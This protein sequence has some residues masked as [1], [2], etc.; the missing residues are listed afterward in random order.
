MFT[1]PV[2]FMKAF[3][4]AASGWDLANAHD[5]GY[6]FSVI[7][8]DTVNNGVVV[9]TDGTK[10][11]TIGNTT[12]SIYQYTLSTAGDIRTASYDSVSFSY[13]TQGT[14]GND[15]FF[16]PDGTA[17]YYVDSGTGF[18]YQYTLSTPWDLS[19]ASYASK[20]FSVVSQETNSLGLTFKSDGTKM[21]IVGNTNDTVYQ[22]TLSTA[23]D[24]STASYDSVSF[25][26]AA[27]DGNPSGIVFKSDGTKMYIVGSASDN[28]Y[29]YTLSTP[30]NVSTATYDS[31]LFYV[32]ILENTPTGLYASS[33]GTKMYLVGTGEDRVLQVNLSSGWD[34][35]TA[36]GDFDVANVTGQMSTVYSLHFKPDGTKM[37]AGTSEVPDAVYQYT[38]S[39][40]WDTD[41]ASYDSVFKDV[42]AQLTG[43]E[44]LTFSVD[45]TK[46]YVTCLAGTGDNT[47]FQYTLSTPWNLSTASYASKSFDFT[48]QDISPVEVWFKTDGTKMYMFGIAGNSVYQ[49]SLSTAWDVSTATYDS[50][51]FSVAAQETGGRGLCFSYDGDKM[52]ISGA[53]TDN[54][55]Q[56][57]LSTPWNLSTASYDSKFFYVGDWG[58]A[59]RQ[60]F[61]KQD[62]GMKMYIAVTS[63]VKQFSLAA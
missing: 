57:T 8:E 38:L 58:A 5:D 22:Y 40:P 63:F 56:Y 9:S 3:E 41:T 10:M 4:A 29:Q 25:S 35:S 47:I 17:F 50:V 59:A 19:T 15:L 27:Q 12:D 1:F 44:G 48:T 54:I 32:G 33:D 21:Y 30:W 20:S 55:Y 62:D 14:T 34:L 28:I 49:Y 52:F 11:Y 46:M 61:I 43:F 23:W 31:V 18:V 51:S 45:G 13:A 2:G 26:V 36:T 60:V 42:S 39:T 24:V 6:N 16:K 7:N 37:Y 53:T